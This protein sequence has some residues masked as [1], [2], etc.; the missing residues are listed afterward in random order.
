MTGCEK[1]LEQ[2]EEKVREYRDL[3][4]SVGQY[5]AGVGNYDLSHITD[6]QERSDVMYDVWY[7]LMYRIEHAVDV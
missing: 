2:C 5:A 6:D 4:I 3:L 7:N 1:A